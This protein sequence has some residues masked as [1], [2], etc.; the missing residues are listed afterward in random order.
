LLLSPY[1]SIGL[2]FSG[3]PRLPG[4]T[5]EAIAREILRR[6]AHGVLYAGT[7]H[8]RFMWV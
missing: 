1:D 3:I 6:N 2:R 4:E 7:G 5:P 8:F